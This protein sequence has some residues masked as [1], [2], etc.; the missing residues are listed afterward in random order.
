MKLLYVRRFRVRHELVRQN[1]IEIY[2]YALRLLIGL[3]ISD[4]YGL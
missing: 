3:H 1:Y 2:I 4:D